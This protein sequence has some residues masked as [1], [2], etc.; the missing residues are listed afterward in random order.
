MVVYRHGKIAFRVVLPDDIQVQE[1]LDFKRLRQ[2]LQVQCFPGLCLVFVDYFLG[3]FV[4]LQCAAVANATIEPGDQETDFI[5]RTAAEAALPFRAL[6]C[7]FRI[8]QCKPILIIYAQKFPPNS[9]NAIPRRN[10][11]ACCF[12]SFLYGQKYDSFLNPRNFNDFYSLHEGQKESKI[13][14]HLPLRIQNPAALP[15][16]SS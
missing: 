12:S 2:F 10:P 5:F 3:Y 7:C 1:L 14:F 13:R 15:S 4:C 6:V 8:F 16:K 11:H 9:R